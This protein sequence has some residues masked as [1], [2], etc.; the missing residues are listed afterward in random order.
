MSIICNDLIKH[1]EKLC[2]EDLAFDW[3]NVGLIIGDRNQTVNKVLIALDPIEE[4][5]D[6]AI[7]CEADMIITHHPL[8]IPKFN[9]AINSI[10]K[11]TH[12]GTLIYKLIKSNIS[13]YCAHTNLDIAKGGINDT[14]AETLGLLDIKSLETEY[15]SNPFNNKG[16]DYGIGRIGKLED[17]IKV[18]QFANIVKSK[19]N[20]K[21]IRII[22]DINKLVQNIAVCSG[23]GMGCISSVIRSNAD[24]LVTGDVKFH[25]AQN[26]L[27]NKICVIDA[28]HYDTEKI[29]VS[30][31]SKYLRGFKELEIFE[32]KIDGNPFNTI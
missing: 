15:D 30:S 10:T 26:A 19:L 3:D 12:L 21:S 9:G 24:I 31:I 20:I 11:D 4:V 18:S 2:P 6:E 27:S 13:L 32:S 23:S 5:I 22:G 14:L 7:A 8:F 25:E 29:M 17:A 16:K 28:G 1:I